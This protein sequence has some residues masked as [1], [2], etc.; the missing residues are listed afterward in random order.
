MATSSTPLRTSARRA[1]SSSSHKPPVPATPVCHWTQQDEIVLL[2]ALLNH[3]KTFDTSSVPSTPSEVAP[4]V[5]LLRGTLSFSDPRP[6]SISDKLRRI[7]HKYVSCVPSGGWSTPHDVSVF[8]LVHQI[9]GSRGENEHNVEG[10]DDNGNREEAQMVDANGSDDGDKEGEEGDKEYYFLNKSLETRTAVGQIEDYSKRSMKKGL[11]LL[12]KSKA[13]K[14][15]T[16]WKELWEMENKV[17]RKRTKLVMKQT[18]WIEKAINF[19]WSS[20]PTS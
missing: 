12:R 14:L 13:R 19:A 11:A 5:D 10:L 18:K 1:S 7:R 20:S 15:N 4:L 2:H 9:W 3:I 6:R 16:E 8:E 17:S